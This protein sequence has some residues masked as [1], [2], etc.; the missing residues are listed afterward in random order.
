MKVKVRKLPK[1]VKKAIYNN[2]NIKLRNI[3][4][5]N[6]IY[7]IE[8]N[9]GYGGLENRVI[10]ITNIYILLDKIKSNNVIWN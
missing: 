4:I 1:P 9:L 2:K 5:L 6:E 10:D 3:F 8:C 7:K